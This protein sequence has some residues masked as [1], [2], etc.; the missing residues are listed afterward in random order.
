[1]PDEWR[2]AMTRMADA[3]RAEYRSFVDDDEFVEYFRLATPLEELGELNIG[4][5]PARRR[6]EGGMES[7]RAIPW[8][9]AWTQMRLMVPSWLGVSEG[10]RTEIER[11]NE[12]ML[13][14]MYEEWPFFRSTLDLI[15]MVLAKAAPE[16]AEHYEA[17][18][19]PEHLRRVGTAL[20]GRFHA[21]VNDVLHVTGEPHLLASN[22]VLRRSIDVRNPYVD[23]IN[24][25]QVELLRRLRNHSG[26]DR[27]LRDALLLTV[28]G[29]AAG[30][31]NTG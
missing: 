22:P 6:K 4:S 30:M 5:R 12:V 29:V 9:F 27:L 25:V 20:R 10:L 24:V 28:N 23:P 21:T 19:V 26:D 8:V 11:G 15:E 17:Q 3:S 31:R 1:V 7:L 13:R 2:E 18:L 14:T 16:I